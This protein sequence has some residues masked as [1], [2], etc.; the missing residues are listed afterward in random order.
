MVRPTDR[1]R[2][3]AMIVTHSSHE[4]ETHHAGATGGGTRA[5]RRLREQGHLLWFVREGRVA[6]QLLGWFE[7]CLCAGSV[8][9]GC[10]KLPGTLVPV[11]G[12]VRARDC[13]QQWTLGWLVCV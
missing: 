13:G 12:V 7:A 4:E 3:A 8:C 11:P 5:V 6:R 9:R 2:T 1:E 10:P